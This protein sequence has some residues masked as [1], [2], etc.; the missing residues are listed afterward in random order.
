MSRQ[1]QR[2]RPPSKKTS[3]AA[4]RGSDRVPRRSGR[5]LGDGRAPHRP[6]AEAQED[7]GTPR[8]A[9]HCPGTAPLPV[10]LLGR[11]CP[12][13]LGPHG[14]AA[15]LH[16]VRRPLLGGAGRLRA[17]DRRWA[18]EADRARPRQGRLA[19][20]RRTQRARARP[21]ALS[22]SVLARVAAGRAPVATLRYCAGESALCVHRG[23]GG[24]A[25]CTLH[26][27]TSP[28]RTGPLH[29]PIPVVAAPGPPSTCTTPRVTSQSNQRSTPLPLT[30]RV[31]NDWPIDLCRPSLTRQLRQD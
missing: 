21:L 20:Q 4:G 16:S 31:R 5:T 7:L 3:A 17:G 29:H 28:S 18:A 26:Q 11:L 6:Q 23:V 19:Y 2:P 15:G 27:L 12:P 1:T 10:A 25:V 24:S 14:L 8:P 9:A 30:G 13:S 22:A